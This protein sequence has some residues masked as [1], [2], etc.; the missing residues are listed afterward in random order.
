M[1]IGIIGLGLIGGSMGLDL[2]AQGFHILGVSRRAQ[3][4][5]QAIDLGVV[6]QASMDLSLMTDADLIVLCTPLAVMESTLA[7][8]KPYLSSDAIVTDVGSVKV[9]VVRHLSPLWPNFVGAHPM[10]GTAESGIEAAQR[11]LFVGRP[12]VITP[13]STTPPDA[14]QKVREIA[15]ALGAKVY[16]C[17]PKAH[18]RAVAWISH[19]PVMISA[20]LIAACMSEEKPEIIELAQQLASSGFRDTSRVGGGNPELGMMMARF[21]RTELLRS[22]S[23]YRDQLDLFIDDIEQ[24]NWLAIEAKLKNTQSSRSFFVENKD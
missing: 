23:C 1:K 18:D 6:D 21:N 4:C 10:A 15:I 11:D 19:L 12:Y 2:R 9:P 14:V 8:L 24:E 7:A 22:L 13:H 3:T 16:E 20:T 17:S 5:Q